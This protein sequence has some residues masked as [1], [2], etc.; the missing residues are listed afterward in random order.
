MLEWARSEL[1]AIGL[2]TSI[3]GSKGDPKDILLAQA[4]KWNADCIFVGT[5]DFRSGFER[6]RLGSVSTGRS[7]QCSLF[8][9]GR[10]PAG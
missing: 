1:N 5:R 9:R 6:L 4:V 3:S 10:S 2:K 8:G 7:N